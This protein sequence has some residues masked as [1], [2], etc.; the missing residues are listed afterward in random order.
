MRRHSWKA[1]G[2][3]GFVVFAIGA[4]GMGVSVFNHHGW[5]DDASERRLSTRVERL[6]IDDYLIGVHDEPCIVHASAL[7]TID[8]AADCF[9][10]DVTI[11]SRPLFL[12]TQPMGFR[13]QWASSTIGAYVEGWSIRA[14]ATD[15]DDEVGVLLDFDSSKMFVDQTHPWSPCD[16]QDVPMDRRFVA[17]VIDRAHQR[18]IYIPCEG[19]VYVVPDVSP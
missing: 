15:G 13:D 11:S 9:S 16:A 4:M 7:E 2:L 14:R 1:L 18:T 5:R 8:N 12:F 6:K 10:R 19:L 3:V 17:Q